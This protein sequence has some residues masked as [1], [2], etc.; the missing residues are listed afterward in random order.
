MAQPEFLVK[1]PDYDRGCHKESGHLVELL[2]SSCRRWVLNVAL[3][4]DEDPIEHAGTMSQISTLKQGLDS[5]FK[6]VGGR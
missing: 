6:H 2:R 1:H 4:H 5:L 3:V